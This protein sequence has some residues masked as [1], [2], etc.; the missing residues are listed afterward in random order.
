MTEVDSLQTRASLLS[1]V[2]HPHD[3]RGWEEFYGRYR[4]L[5]VGLARRGGLTDSDAQDALQETMIAVAR[6][7]PS[8][9]YDPAKGSF[10][11]WLSRIVRCRVVDQVR[12]RSREPAVDEA[13]LEQLA[14]TAAPEHAAAWDEEWKQHIL[15]EAAVRTRA[16][17]SPKQYQL[18][19][20]FVLKQAAMADVKRL[21]RVNAPQV[22]VAKLRVGSVFRRA[23]E[24]VRKE[25][26]PG[27]LP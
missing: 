9:R 5:I 4:G 2:R 21:L 6:Q 17:V 26:E 15:Q 18:F 14:N 11:G 10:K 20:L 25:V 23:L 22:Y 1:R 27:E 12:R 16:Q 8:F 13:T 24:A 7:M 3:Q 19:D